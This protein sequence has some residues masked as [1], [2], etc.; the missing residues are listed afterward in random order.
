MSADGLILDGVTS[1]GRGTLDLPDEVGTLVLDVEITGTATVDFE[2]L[3][4]D[5]TWHAVEGVAM[6]AQATRVSSTSSSGL[7]QVPVGALKKFGA[8]VSSITSG[9][10]TVRARAT[11][12]A[13]IAP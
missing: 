11:E 5:G 2:G 1:T 3:V 8:N 9:S 12:A 10:V 6:D 7:F 13:P 4:K